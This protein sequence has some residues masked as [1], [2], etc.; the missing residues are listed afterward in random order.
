MEKYLLKNSNDESVKRTVKVNG[1][2]MA[3]WDHVPDLV[4]VLGW[5]IVLSQGGS[6]APGAG[7]NIPVGPSVGQS[8][9]STVEPSV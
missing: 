6:V 4:E 7:L 8:V 2:D 3:H 1:W 9:G 5:D